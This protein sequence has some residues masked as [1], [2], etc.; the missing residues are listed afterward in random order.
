MNGSPEVENYWTKC[1]K[2][3]LCRKFPVKTEKVPG[4]IKRRAA[5]STQQQ[6]TLI[7]SG[8]F[9]FDQTG[10]QIKFNIIKPLT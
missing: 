7:G 1:E 6:Q 10:Q 2:N 9:G 3:H 4:K 8:Y 5:D